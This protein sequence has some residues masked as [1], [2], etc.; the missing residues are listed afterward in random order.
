LGVLDEMKGPCESLLLKSGEK[1]GHRQ[2]R[3]FLS[4]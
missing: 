2:V 1:K 4:K 3:Q